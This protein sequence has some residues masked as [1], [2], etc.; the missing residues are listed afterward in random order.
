LGD[1]TAWDK[2]PGV[3]GDITPLVAVTLA[4]FGLSKHA[5]QVPAFY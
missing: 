4:L 5:S 2:R 1:S 3:S